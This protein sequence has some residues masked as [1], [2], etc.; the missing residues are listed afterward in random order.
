MSHNIFTKYSRRLENY[1]S[2]IEKI[3]NDI[4]K[5]NRQI[6]KN[7]FRRVQQ[8]VKI[9]TGH[10]I[11]LNCDDIEDYSLDYDENY[12]KPYNPIF[13]K[14]FINK[15]SILSENK[16]NGNK[17]PS[18]DSLPNK[19]KN[20]ISGTSNNLDPENLSP[21]IANLLK[22]Y[23][24]VEASKKILLSYTENDKFPTFQEFLGIIGYN[25]DKTLKGFKQINQ[26]QEFHRLLIVYAFCFYLWKLDIWEKSIQFNVQSKLEEKNY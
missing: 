10:D 14:G 9:L 1:F 11:N 2:N 20:F 6:E 3:I 5:R 23:D 21:E 12:N 25:Y 18:M 17:R 8:R 13:E 15:Q 24:K 7:I 26:N 4:V 19:T 16:K 22:G